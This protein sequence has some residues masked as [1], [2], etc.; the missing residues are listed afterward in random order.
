MFHHY[1]ILLLQQGVTLLW[2]TSIVPQLTPSSCQEPGTGCSPPTRAQFGFLYT[3][4]GIMSI[5]SACIRPCSIAFGADQLKH[6]KNQRLIDSYFNWY[7][8]SATISIAIASTVVV[9]IQDRFGWRV[10]FAV[11]VLAMF[12]SVLMFL[13]GSPLYVK[14]KVDKSPF[15]GLIQVLIVAFRNRKIRLLPDDCY[16]YS[17]DMDQVELTDGLRF[18]NKACVVRDVDIGFSGSNLCGIPTVENVES[19]KSLIR[20]V[21][22]WSSGILVFVNL[23]QKFP[24]LEAEKMNRRITS[25]FEIPA[26][27]FNLFMLLTITI[28]IPFYDRVMVPFLAKFTHEPRGL[29]LKTRM[30]VGI[31]LSIVTMVV[32]AIVE[33][34]RRDLANSN[35]RVV[36]SAMWLVPQFVLLGLT[37]AFNG[38]GQL[39]F[40]YSE[41]PNSMPSLAMVMFKVSMAVASLIA[42]LLTNIVDSVTGQGGGVSWLSS[43]IDEGHVDYYYWLLSFLTL[44]NF[45]YYLICCRL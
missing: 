10:G 19:L 14:V 41:L 24:T 21:P 1:S 9:Y 29:N 37:E 42:S 17:N 38:I 36:M 18:L 31:I 40:Y 7:Y 23:L 25:S 20:I 33:T 39:E 27:S 28:W 13:L 44:L 6:H 35:M 2:L 8:A 45:V 16:N 34:I 5:G 30:G 26:A 22:I 11:P 15:S 4:F 32:S 3:S 43:D 12:C